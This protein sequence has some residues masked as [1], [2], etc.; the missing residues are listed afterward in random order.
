M[1]KWIILI[2]FVVVLAIA[3]GNRIYLR[4]TQKSAQSIGAIQ[5]KTGLPVQV[6][7]VQQQDMQQTV[8]ISGSIKGFREVNISPTITERIKVIHVATSQKVSKGQL[9][10][11]LDDTSNKLKL[12][13]NQASLKQV[14][15]VL[16]RLRN[17]AR[18]E[19]IEIARSTMARAQADLALKNLEYQRQKQLYQEEATT[20]QR[21]EQAQAGFDS[22]Q[23]QLESTRANYQMIKKGPRKEDIL[24]AQARVELAHVAVAQ[25]KKDLDDHYL[26]APFAGVVC[27]RMLEEGDVAEKNKSIFLLLDLDDVYLD[28]DVSELYVSK[29]AIGMKVDI[30]VDSL[31]D[32]DFTGTLSEINP[33]ANLSDR[34]YV[35]RIIIDNSQGLLKSGMFA[36]AKIVID[37]IKQAI[38]VSRDAIK[39][40]D[41]QEY[42]LMVDEN[43]IVQKVDVQV[44]RMFDDKVEITKG[45]NAG[46]NVI[47]LSYNVQP[48]SKVIITQ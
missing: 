23:A 22:A 36:R 31:E 24:E 26:K 25:E 16:N 1:K 37:Q 14:Q 27:L 40:Q 17:G 45:L 42:V 4:L 8:D 13:R 12:A 30:H 32:R 7:K 11:T 35:T 44:G 48:G 9:L 18:P 6:Y 38:V 29:I 46:T 3:G 20:L 19:E 34:S 47:T 15:Q 39:H 10:V 33:I 41:G 2:L 28:L 21:L 43:N 5:E